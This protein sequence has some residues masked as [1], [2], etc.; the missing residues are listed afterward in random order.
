MPSWLSVLR[1]HWLMSAL[2][3][4]GLSSASA[5]ETYTFHHENVL[6]TSLEIQ[7]EAATPS[8]ATD[9]ESRI[10][11]EI[12]RQSKIFS[13]YDATSE[14]SVWQATV[15]DSKTI[16]PELFSVLKASQRWQLVS[17]GAFNPAAEV[18]TKVWQKAEKRNQL[19]SSSEMAE[20][21]AL[22]QQKHWSL[23]EQTRTA[24]HLSNVPLS[25]NAVAKGAI[26]DAASQVALQ[27]SNVHGVIVNIGGDLRVS[28]QSV[29]QVQIANPV[30][31]AVNAQ[32]ITV[33]FLNNRAV[34]TS[35]NYRR[36]F[37]IDGKW[38]SHIVDPRTG[39]TATGIASAT[40][41][42]ESSTDADALATILN[43]LPADKGLALIE[44]MPGIECLIVAT[45]GT[46]SR[47]AGWNHLEQPSLFRFAAAAPREVALAGQEPDA[48][49]PEAAQ[50]AAPAVA[51]NA[52]LELVVKFELN[53][54]SG[55]QYRRPYVA[56]WLEDEDEFPVRTAV[57]WM[58]T[59]QPGPRWH[60]DLLRWFRNDGVRKLADGTDL[61][62]TISSAT[63]AAGE[64]KAVFDG[65]DD[66][67]KLLKPGKYTLFIE[68]AREH[69]TY[70]LIRHKLVLGSDPIAETKL[71]EN[72]EI[73]SASVEYRAPKTEPA[74]QPAEKK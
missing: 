46:Q 60:R 73:K 55:A 59:K 2:L 8:A 26:V 28:G 20:A 56:I 29:R 33:V 63:R 27:D 32:P 1:L 13:T 18:I 72:V 11:K 6:G 39:H 34:A 50:P 51:A 58:Q 35:G 38:Y 43:V 66:A 14:F 30:H 62:G 53:R 69:G 54:P 70:Q 25:L 24:K 42:A 64:Y 37:E 41:V 31:D 7:L 44:S 17:G 15:G 22:A 12:Q 67:G 4:C 19:P 40:V 5:S 74:A 10:L 16:S 61:I 23:D 52:L 36:G 45:D 71:K 3:C 9:A 57:L 21:A 65:K 49:K 48:A 47:S 68:V